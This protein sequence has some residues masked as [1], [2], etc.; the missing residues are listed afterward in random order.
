MVITSFSSSITTSTSV[1]DIGNYSTKL[2]NIEPQSCTNFFPLPPNPILI[3]TP[4]ESG[5][6]PL[7]LFLH[8]YLP[9]SLSNISPLMAS[10][11]WFLSCIRYK[12]QIQL[13]K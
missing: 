5:S 12:E 13:R 3:A 7:V 10:L 11:L 2:L 9:L 8:G 6:F 4:S 1:F